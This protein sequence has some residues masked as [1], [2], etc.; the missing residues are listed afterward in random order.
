MQF[1]RYDFHAYVRVF[2]TRDKKTRMVMVSVMHVM[3]TLMEMESSTEKII[4]SS[5]VILTKQMMTKTEL[6]MLVTIVLM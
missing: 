3:M 6:V 2:Q 5:S 4:V 1:V